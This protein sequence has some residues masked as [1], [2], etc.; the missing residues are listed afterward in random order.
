MTFPLS[1]FAIP[2]GSFQLPVD[3]PSKLEGVCDQL[4]VSFPREWQ[5]Y[6]LGALTQLTLQATWKGTPEEQGAAMQAAWNMIATFGQA[7]CAPTSPEVHGG[8]DDDMSCPCWRV[9]NN[10]LQF[11]CCGE[12]QD[13]INVGQ[14]G[15]P[16]AG[17]PQPPA[18]GG[19]AEYC[20]KCPGN[21]MALLPTNVS[22]GDVILI[23]NPSGAWFDGNEF[24]N[25]TCPNGWR[26]FA[27][28]CIYAPNY[29]S[30]DPLPLV[31][32]MCLIAQIGGTYYNVFNSDLAGNP[33]PFT[34]PAGHTNDPVTF[35]PNDHVPS[36]NAGEISFCVKV[37]NNSS[38]SW[39]HDFD[40]TVGSYPSVFDVTA[41][42]EP[43]VWASGSGYDY[44][45]VGSAANY[46]IALLHSAGITFDD[47]QAT[48]IL[49]NNDGIESIGIQ[50][51][52]S[53]T[54]IVSEANT[55][56]THHLSTGSVTPSHDVD[57]VGESNTSMGT[58]SGRLT[59]VRLIGH[60]TDPYA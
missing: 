25:W 46:K 3:P 56:G 49:V 12:W 6:I 40:L 44:T 37:T 41:C 14:P 16:G 58:P 21:G 11:F 30:L 52:C 28:T 31:L 20:L 23:E 1:P 15:Q 47:I 60:G 54:D 29:D 48:F 53:A 4:T 5:P 51:N 50:Q 26:F 33:Q 32:D 18:G 34:V 39:S 19:T 59:F 24:V 35:L 27:G 36:G 45:I 42:G 17:S 2:V 9:Q 57:F 43:A 13:V 10:T 55:N 7:R 8:E 22:T 38:L